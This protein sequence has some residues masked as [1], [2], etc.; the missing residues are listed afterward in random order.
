MTASHSETRRK[1]VVL[2]SGGL[3]S[4]VCAA[5]T[6]HDDRSVQ[7]RVVE[8]VQPVD[9]VV[10]PGLL[11]GEQEHGTMLPGEAVRFHQGRPAPRGPGGPVV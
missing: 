8:D 5:I 3:D 10:E 7:R 6:R 1:A 4:M 9:L 2:L 11:L